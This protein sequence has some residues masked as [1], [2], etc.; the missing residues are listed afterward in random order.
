MLLDG[1]KE[2]GLCLHG[3]VETRIFARKNPWNATGIIREPDSF[4]PSPMGETRGRIGISLSSQRPRIGGGQPPIPGPHVRTISTTLLLA[5]LSV[6]FTT[7]TRNS[8]RFPA[9]ASA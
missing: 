3:A 7:T 8:A 6:S 4:S 1:K 9:L 5:S 2:R